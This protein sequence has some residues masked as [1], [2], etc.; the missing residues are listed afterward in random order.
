MASISDADRKL[1]WG[2]SGTECAF[3]HCAQLLTAIPAEEGA[4]S[5]STHPIVVGEEAHIVAEKDDGPRG[6]RSMP[7]PERNAYPNLILLCRKHHVI[8]DKDHGIHFSVTQLRDMKAEHEASV[9]SRLSTTST[10][11]EIAARDRQDIL[12]EAASASR[13]R[14]VA[15]GVAAGANAELAQALADDEAVGA[16]TRLGPALPASGLVILEGDFGSGKSVTGERIYAAANA[17]AIADDTAP[18]PAHLIA[19]SITGLLTD[20]IRSTVDGLGEPSHNGLRLVLDGLD[21]PGQA[22]ALELLNEARALVHTWPN[23]RIVVT[24]RP[25]LPLNSDE[26]KLT[27]PPLSDEE[28]VALVERLGGHHSLLWQQSEPIRQMLRLP[29]FLI[30]ATLQQQ[31]G[32]AIPRSR[33]TFL[34]ALAKAALIRSGHSGEQTRQALQSLACLTIEFGGTAP[35]AELGS[36]EAVRAVLESRLVVREGH[37]LRFALPVVEQYFAAQAVLHSGLEVLDLDDLGLLDRW[38]DS[39]TLA[40]TLGS[41]QQVSDVLGGLAAK[42]PGLAAWLVANA[43]PGPTMESSGSLPGHLACARRLQHTLSAWVDALGPVNQFLGLRDTRGRLRTVGAFVEGTRVTAAVRVGD[44]GGVAAMQLP[45]GLNP[46]T[47]VAPDG[48]QWGLLHGGGVPAEF[49]AWPWQWGLDWV[50]MNVEGVLRTKA[51]PLPDNRPFRDERRWHLARCIVGKS[52]H[53]HHNPIDGAELRRTTADIVAQLDERGISQYRVMV[54]GQPL[55]I[56]GRDELAALVNEIDEGEILNKDGF[57]HRPYPVPDHLPGGGYVY[58]IYSN[59]AL[60]LLIEQAHT[61]ALLIYRDLVMTWFPTLAPTLGLASFMPILIRGH[62]LD[63]GHPS[64]E[65][66]PVPRFTYRMTPVSLT[67]SSRAEIE[68][69]TAPGDFL[70]FDPQRAAEQYLQLMQQIAALH[71]GTEGWAS[72]QAASSS[73]ALWYDTP[74]TSL[75]YR[76]LWEDLRRLH[77]VK[78]HAQNDD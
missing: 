16:A 77:L 2:H 53:L 12:L 74:G 21:E 1:L 43:V 62:L 23:T 46:F 17:A 35:A 15:Q 68:L 9:R 47:G 10:A 13:G 44:S 24:S 27:Y 45:T 28:A 73:G 3:P 14:L 52:R 49:V 65:G 5:G 25:G 58:Q 26:V 72:V 66:I 69:I 78:Q 6:D 19:K 70:E 20:A 51:L 64:T 40:V 57:F 11:P 55:T 34:D 22:R 36:D 54:P 48:S 41:W 76:W 37:S 59:E 42:H 33:G 18:L 7:V 61:N 63:S 56:F 30:V 31:A 29:L 4:E 39:L 60:R 38:R 67:E 8:I 50:V 32:A 71:P 75:A